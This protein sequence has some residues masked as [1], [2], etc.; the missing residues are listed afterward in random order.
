MKNLPFK[1]KHQRKYP[2]TEFCN[3]KRE[4]M[5]IDNGSEKKGIKM[6]TKLITGWS[7]FIL[8]KKQ[9]KLLLPCF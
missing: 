1:D 6:F 8:T 7:Q 9:Y 4:E 2:P 3:T 5:S